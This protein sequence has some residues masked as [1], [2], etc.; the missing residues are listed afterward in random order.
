[1]GCINMQAIIAIV[2]WTSMMAETLT[3]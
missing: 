3:T 1:M 2:P